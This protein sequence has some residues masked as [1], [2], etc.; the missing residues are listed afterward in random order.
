VII[1]IS[2]FNG[3]LRYEKHFHK[4]KRI[5]RKSGKQAFF[6]LKMGKNEVKM[7]D[8]NQK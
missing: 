7:P 5:F 2:F 3:Q 1:W 6:V 4:N 8:F